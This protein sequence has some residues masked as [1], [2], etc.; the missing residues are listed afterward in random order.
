MPPLFPRKTINSMKKLRLSEPQVLDVFNKGKKIKL[1]SGAP[2]IVR[3]YSGYEIGLI[4]TRDQIT[5]EYIITYVWK[6]DR[7]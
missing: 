3:K 7:R 4:Y 6:K 1:S 5:G 2:A